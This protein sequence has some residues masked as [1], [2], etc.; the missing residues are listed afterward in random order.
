MKI[1][2]IEETEY[3]RAPMYAIKVNDSAIQWFSKKEDAEKL[4]ESILLDPSILKTKKI[5]LKSQEIDVSSQ[6]NN[7]TS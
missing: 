5:I 4:Y 6:E 2:L 1:E 3:T 7:Q